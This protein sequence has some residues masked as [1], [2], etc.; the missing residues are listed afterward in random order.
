M[1]IQWKKL[2]THLA[3]PLLVG[4][5]SALLTRNSME[6]YQNLNQ[7]PLAPPG[8]LFPVVWTILFLLM[9]ISSYLVDQSHIPEGNR[10]TLYYSL[11]LVANFA[12]SIVFFLWGQVIPAFIILLLLLYF[13]LRMIF[14]F[15]AVR[16]AAAWLQIPYLLWVLFAGYLNLAI[17]FLNGPSL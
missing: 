13:I 16:P 10:S 15:Y 14:S 11:Q 12:W 5:L 2:I 3:V 9:G 17:Y 1:S 8:W 6:R 7:P 4:G